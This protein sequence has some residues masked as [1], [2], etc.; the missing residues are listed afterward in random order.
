MV[1]KFSSF[2]KPEDWRLI[3]MILL[4]MPSAT[5]LVSKRYP[6]HHL[7]RSSFHCRSYPV[8][9]DQTCYDASR[10][11]SIFACAHAFG[12]IPEISQ[13]VIVGKRVSTSLR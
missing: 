4:L 13:L 1:L 5:A 3:D 10:S 7:D 11:R 12:V 8:S 2:R 9:Y 6:L